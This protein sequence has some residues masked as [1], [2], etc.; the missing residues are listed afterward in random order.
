[1]HTL[2]AVTINTDQNEKIPTDEDDEKKDDHV[3]QDFSVALSNIIE[4]AEL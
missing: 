1:M 2:F 4:D 3:Q